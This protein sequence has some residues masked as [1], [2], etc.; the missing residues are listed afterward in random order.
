MRKA[1]GP[2]PTG[3]GPVALASA[4]QGAGPELARKAAP[5]AVGPAWA[6]PSSFRST[7]PTAPTH[8]EDAG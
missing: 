1:L 2:S 4:P 5:A 6:G 7:N 3:E 8:T